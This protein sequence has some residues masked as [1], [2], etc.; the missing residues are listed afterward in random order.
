[1]PKQFILLLIFCFGFQLNAQ[2]LGFKIPDY[3]AIEKE[4]N[5]KNSKF[6]YPKLMERLVKNDT[7]LTHDEYSHLYLG[8]FFQ[9]KYNAF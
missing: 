2:D 1:M 7:L 9:P 4:I 3:K 6:F 5:D 8:Y